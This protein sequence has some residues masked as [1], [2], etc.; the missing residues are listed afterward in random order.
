MR[1]ALLFLIGVMLLFPA[2]SG[3]T[4]WFVKP[5]G[6][7]DCTTIQA[8]IDSAAVGDTVLVTCPHSLYHFLS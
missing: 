4:T 8:C 7:A 5:D 3:G 2:T 1:L 6:S